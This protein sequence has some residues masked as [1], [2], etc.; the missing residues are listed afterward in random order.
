MKK[1]APAMS[2]LF[3][4]SLLTSPL[5][6]QSLFSPADIAAAKSAGAAAAGTGASVSYKHDAQGNLVL[7]PNGAPVVE[8]RTNSSL[9][10]DL[11]QFKADTGLAGV[12]PVS[13]PGSAG[14]TGLANVKLNQSFTFTCKGRAG[15][16][17]GAAS[18]GFR[19][20]GCEMSGAAISAVRFSICEQSAA[21]G[22][23]AVAADFDQP[24]RIPAN[25]Y[26]AFKGLQLGLGCNS[27]GTCQLTATGAYSM[28]G[29]DQS[30]KAQATNVSSNVR[31]G[32]QKAITEGDYAGK[33]T[34]IGRPLV[35]ANTTTQTQTGSGSTNVCAATPSCLKEATTTTAFT[36]SCIRTFPLTE[37]K[38]NYNINVN[39]TATCNSELFKAPLPGEKQKPDTNSCGV[40][41][42][43][44]PPGLT[45]VGGT[46][47]TC[48]PYKDS[49]KN[50]GCASYTWTDYWVDLSQ[51]TVVSAT[52]SP[53]PVQGACDTRDEA[54]STLMTCP[55]GN[56]FGRTT[57]GSCEV[58]VVDDVNGNK[59]G[60]VFPL[61]YRTVMDKQNHGQNSCGICLA[62]T[63]GNVCYGRPGVASSADTV[64][65]ADTSVSCNDAKAMDLN[66]CTLKSAVPMVISSPGGLVTTQKETYQCSQSK[67]VCVAWG[68]GP[69]SPTCMSNDLAMGTDKTRP[70]QQSDGSMNSAMI[71]AALADS[72]QRG[73]EVG[74]SQA[75]P[76]VFGGEDLRCHRPTGGLGTVL[77][78]NCCGMDLERPKKGNVVQGGCSLDEAKLSAARRSSYATYIGEYCSRSLKF[79]GFKKC[80]ENTQAYCV[81]PGILPRLVQEQGRAQLQQMLGTYQGD[82]VKQGALAFS[83][84]SATQDGN[85]APRTS[86]NGVSFTAWQW[87]AYCS[88][89]ARAA[90]VAQANPASKECPGVVTTYLAAC[91][92]PAGCGPLPSEPYEGSLNW[93]LASVDPL[94][95]VTNAVS[96]YGVA[97][98]ACS[99][100]T[101]KCSYALKAWPAGLGGRA[102]VSKDVTWTLFSMEQVATSGQSPAS[103]RMNSIGDLM[104][105]GYAVSGAAGGPA[106]ATVPLG[107][108]RDGGQTWTTLNI[109]SDLKGKEMTLPGSEVTITGQCDGS[110][111]ACAYR[112]VGTV[113]VAMK[114]WGSPQRPDCTGFSAGQLSAID[115]GKMDLSEWLVTVMDKVGAKT[116][117]NLAAQANSQFQAFN[118]LFQTGQVKA[119]SPAV[120]FA[121]AVPAE[122]FG[123]FPVRLAVSGIWP[124]VT[125]DPARDTDVV[126]GVEVDWGDCKPAEVLPPIDPR[127]GRGYGN[128]HQYFTPD[129]QSYPCL[130]GTN[131]NVTHRII[132]TVH[133]TNSGVQKR[134]VSVE[135]AYARFPGADS[136]NSNVTTTKTAPSTTSKVPAPPRPK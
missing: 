116:P 55:S 121:R 134:A 50:P 72:T 69:N 81:F 97:T 91:D 14:R 70:N 80:L 33:M 133:T 25:R 15:E 38:T 64:D 6:A 41:I 109:P 129:A 35:D 53:S 125:G 28:G 111:N 88:D 71:A 120:N 86:V 105:K 51:R 115:F 23:C 21:A 108:S 95:N 43:Q 123:P 31:D 34:E 102:I 84:Y 119:T 29:S 22:V 79:L 18:L 36:K 94:Q 16:A 10:G 3:A 1:F 98:G 89:P 127:Q 99:T 7:G 63:I 12:D 26:V 8:R 124:E 46:E 54:D 65:Y 100:E 61:D 104:F 58:S 107:F 11:Q 47:M 106:P 66:N 82:G 62:P 77:Q 76:K 44:G 73:L 90:Q 24:A 83:Y 136:N 85:W 132:L 39:A 56:W 103:Y 40:P 57:T 101:L 135:N 2:A 19:V 59:T 48:V 5:F 37:R 75:L 112:V 27:V 122:G 130:A 114:P 17:Y 93:K 45:R 110:A 87:P 42:E 60:G 30:M 117:Q 49:V 4:L 74:S 96:R 126:T 9:A 118:S 68:A 20:D 67:A 78:K 13:S 113:V 92:L 32:L 128:V 52:E 131:A